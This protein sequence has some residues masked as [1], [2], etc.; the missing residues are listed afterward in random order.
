MSQT[1][2]GV[3]EFQEDREA[4]GIDAHGEASCT[5]CCPPS[6]HVPVNMYNPYSGI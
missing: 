5:G 3:K 6:L 2:E 1:D 4:A